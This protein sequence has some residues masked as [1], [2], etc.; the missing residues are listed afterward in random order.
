VL[1]RGQLLS[2]SELSCLSCALQ[3]T[4]AVK[5]HAVLP[6]FLCFTEDSCC[7]VASCLACL[8][9]YRG[10]L[11]SSGML[12]YLSLCFTEDS[13]RQVA[14]CLACLVLYRGQLPSSGML[15]CLSCA[16]QSRTAA[17]KWHAVLLVLCF[18]QDSCRQMACCLACLALCRG[19]LLSFGL[20]SCLSRALQTT[21]PS[22]GLLSCLSCALQRTA[23]VSWVVVLPVSCFTEDS[24]RQLACCHACLVLHRG[25]LLS[26]GLLSC[27]SRA[28]QRTAPVNW[29]AVLL[30][31]CFTEDCCCQLAC[32]LACLVLRT[33]WL[34][35]AKLLSCVSW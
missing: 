16:L 11:P 33:A 3:R 22:I 10:Q 21:A 6:V 1:Y 20:L 2:S 18:T 27:L 5:W 23:P 24:C 4:A 15:S 13:C 25:L 19:P 14:C 26:F 12:S 28:S 8:V 29:L 31:L 7:Q 35:F 34:L 32:C 17:V 9:L 30:V